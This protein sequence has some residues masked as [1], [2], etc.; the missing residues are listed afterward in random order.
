MRDGKFAHQ[1]VH[2]EILR[3]L[4]GHFCIEMQHDQH[5]DAGPREELRLG[6]E[7]GEPKWAGVRLKEFAGIRF[8]YHGGKRPAFGLRN[9]RRMGDQGAMAAM[10]A[11]KIAERNDGAFRPIRRIPVVPQDPHGTILPFARPRAPKDG[12]SAHFGR[13]GTRTS[14]S[15]STTT[16]SATLQAQSKVT[17]LRD[18]LISFTVHT[19]VTVSPIRTG[20]LNRTVAP[21]K[22]EP[23]PGSLVP[24]T[25]EI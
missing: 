9:L 6:A 12:G 23:A 21:R 2:D 17:R 25:V 10:H 15:H 13:D 18:R 24:S 20:D 3:E 14:V 7:R 4:S 11:V 22:I 8:E 16:A 19:A 5:I 1:H